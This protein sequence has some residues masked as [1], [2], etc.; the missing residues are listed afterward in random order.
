MFAFRQLSPHA[1]FSLF[2]PGVSSL[3]SCHAHNLSICF[4]QKTFGRAVRPTE[5]SAETVQVRDINQVI[6]GALG[7][8]LQPC[9]SKASRVAL[10]LP[11]DAGSL[12]QL[13]PVRE[14]KLLDLWSVR[15]PM[16][17][18]LGQR[19]HVSTLPLAR[20]PFPHP[21]FLERIFHTL[22]PDTCLVYARSE[23]QN[24]VTWVFHWCLCSRQCSDF[25]VGMAFHIEF[26][27]AKANNSRPFQTCVPMLNLN[28]ANFSCRR[29]SP[30]H[31]LGLLLQRLFARKF[32]VM[33]SSGVG[34]VPWMHACM[35]VVRILRTQNLEIVRF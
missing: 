22:C 21:L 12:T 1:I 17:Q 35:L 14:A 7:G 27:L 34:S 9:T 16:V 31:P 30:H 24:H 6:A 18:P 26:F 8:L 11:F 23:V 25:F 15:E 2:L 13:T 10:S 5:A 4:S 20:V 3:R 32:R 28:S 19:V 29:L 33:T